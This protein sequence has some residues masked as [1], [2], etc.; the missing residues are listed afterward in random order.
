M[1]SI[2]LPPRAMRN[3]SPGAVADDLT[4]ESPISTLPA[5]T[6]SAGNGRRRRCRDLALVPAPGKKQQICITPLPSRKGQTTAGP[7][8]FGS[9][10]RLRVPFQKNVYASAIGLCKNSIIMQSTKPSNSDLYGAFAVNLF[11]DAA[12]P[13]I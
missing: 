1:P 6:A 8:R 11:F 12:P 4:D 10:T 9:V 3:S 13:L 2:T 7:K 5:V